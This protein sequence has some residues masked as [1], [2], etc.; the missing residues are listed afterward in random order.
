MFDL[1]FYCGIFFTIFRGDE[2]TSNF[3]SQTLLFNT[4]IDFKSEK[5]F[6][7]EI[8][9][10]FSDCERIKKKYKVLSPDHRS[11]I[12]SMNGFSSSSL[13][14]KS[15][16]KNGLENHHQNSRD[17]NQLGEPKRILY[18][19]DKIILVWKKVT[20]KIIS[21]FLLQC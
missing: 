5:D 11:Q 20:S 12:F 3:Y 17:D 4:K 2:K 9:D 21:K 16:N 14:L 1:D 8:D 10:D 15:P 19:P 7:D 13:K 6:D 18:S